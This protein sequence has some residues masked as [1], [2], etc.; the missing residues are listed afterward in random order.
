MIES[1]ATVLAIGSAFIAALAAF[2]ARWQAMAAARANEI[3]IH[4]SR[5]NVYRGLARFRVHITAHGT[6]IKEEEVWRFAEIAELSEFYFPPGIHPRL[7]KIF[8]DA[9]KLLSLNDQ[10]EDARRRNDEQAKVLVK[11]RHELMKAM[12]DECY[13]ITGELKPYLLVGAANR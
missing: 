8:Q 10:W 3:A 7:N 13:D 11:E 9:L 4:E 1:M 12:R 2:Y 5:L 6:N